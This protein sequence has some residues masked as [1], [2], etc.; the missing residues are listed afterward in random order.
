MKKIGL[1][2]QFCWMQLQK[3]IVSSQLTEREKTKQLKK[4]VAHSML[5]L[6]LLRCWLC[7][8]SLSHLSLPHTICEP[9]ENIQEVAMVKFVPN[10]HAC[11]A[12]QHEE[13]GEQR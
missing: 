12:E 3:H 5:L 7:N 6:L 1:S 9:A 8:C 11:H 10:I 13:A 2:L 4:D